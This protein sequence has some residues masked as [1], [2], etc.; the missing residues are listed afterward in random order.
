MMDWQPIETAPKDGR[1]VLVYSP[2][3][4]NSDMD[5]PPLYVTTARFDAEWRGGVW[6]HH[7][8]DGIGHCIKGATMWA[9]IRAPDDRSVTG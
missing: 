7:Y 2:F 3:G 1:W 4:V 6:Y 5:D 8:A 9:P